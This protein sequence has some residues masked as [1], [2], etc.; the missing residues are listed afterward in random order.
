[1]HGLHEQS[2]CDIGGCIKLRLNIRFSTASHMTATET[3]LQ[4]FRYKY[5]LDRPIVS[6]I[7]DLTLHSPPPDG[8]ALKGTEDDVLDEQANQDHHRQSCEYL[9]CVQFIAILE[10]IPAQPAF[11]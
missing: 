4:P 9:V 3:P 1:M 7:S 10:N 2:A 5:P 11:A 6:C 8:Q